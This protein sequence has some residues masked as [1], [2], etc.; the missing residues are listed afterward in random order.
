MNTEQQAPRITNEYIESRINSA[1]YAVFDTLTICILTLKNGYKVTG[2]SSC[3]SPESFNVDLEQKIARA[4]AVDK[5]WP[6]EG[7]LLKDKLAAE[8][9]QPAPQS[10]HPAW[11]QRVI[12]ETAE[13]QEKLDKL[14]AY[15]ANMVED[16]DAN[17]SPSLLHMQRTAMQV[18]LDIL[19]QRNE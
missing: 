4:N 1:E 12:A 11:Q 16:A 14:D 10:S 3:V 6:L 7:Y 8:Q 15:L 2:E 18:Y 5:I 19:K 17:R 9:Q 13:L